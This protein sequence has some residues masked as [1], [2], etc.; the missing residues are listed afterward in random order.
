MMIEMNGNNQDNQNKGLN[1][2]ENEKDVCIE[3]S[4]GEQSCKCGKLL[5]ISGPSGVG[6]TEVALNLREYSP[7]YVKAITSTTRKM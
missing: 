5:V 3:T 6:K 7:I 2:G 1:K 4:S